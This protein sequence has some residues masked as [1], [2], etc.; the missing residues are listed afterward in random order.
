LVSLPGALCVDIA[1][2]DGASAGLDARI[3]VFDLAIAISA[4]SCPVNLRRWSAARPVG[5]RNSG[6][7]TQPRTR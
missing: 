4:L 1:G 7:W 5:P 6:Y 2:C 3:P